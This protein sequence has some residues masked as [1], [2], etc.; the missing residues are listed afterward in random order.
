MTD[1]SIATQQVRRAVYAVTGQTQLPGNQVN[2]GTGTGFL[3]A[4]GTLV[5]VAHAIHLD[6]NPTQPVHTNLAVLHCDGIGRSAFQP[7]SLIREDVARDIALLRITDPRTDAVALRAERL[8]VGSACGSVGFPLSGP[9]AQTGGMD[10]FERFQG[11][12][13]SAHRPANIDGGL[14]TMFYESDS[15]MY[16][17]SSGCPMFA[18]DGTV[19]AMQKASFN[20]GQARTSISLSIPVEEIVAFAQS[21]GVALVQ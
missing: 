8:A 6:G 7:C 17:G 3:I 1:F 20:H 21:A 12:Y 9:N 4:P 13:V 19:F 15:L 14:T 18:E 5:T 11:A 10:V 2:V 16:P